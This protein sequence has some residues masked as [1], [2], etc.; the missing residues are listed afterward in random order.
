MTGASRGIGVAIV[1]ALVDAG[2]VRFVAVDLTTAEGPLEL[3]SYAGGTVDVLVNN[4]GG[5]PARTEGF[6]AVTDEMW[7]HT[8]TLNLLAAVRRPARSSR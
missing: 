8:L 5:V 2:K 7:L 4:V 6:L 3:V 1:G